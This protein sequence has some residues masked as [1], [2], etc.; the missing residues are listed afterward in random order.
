MVACVTNVGTGVG[1]V[2]N[3][4]GYDVAAASGYAYESNYADQL[5]A[6][7]EVEGIAWYEPTDNPANYAISDSS[8]DSSLWRQKC[9]AKVDFP[10]VNNEEYLGDYEFIYGFRVYESAQS[11]LYFEMTQQ[12]EQAHLGDAVYSDTEIIDEISEVED[13]YT[14]EVIYEVVDI[15]VGVYFGYPA[16]DLM[17]TQSIE[18]VFNIASDG[19][20]GSLVITMNT[21]I[22]LSIA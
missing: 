9:V 13:T 22:P 12:R 7:P 4:N 16:N 19:L 3:Y 18:G 5:A 14:E 17:G 20:S 10:K 11:T 8:S 2:W 6:N 21:T 15:D 1:A